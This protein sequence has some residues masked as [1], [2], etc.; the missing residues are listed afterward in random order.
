[1][2]RVLGIANEQSRA[3]RRHAL[4]ADIKEGR[5]RGTLWT[6]KTDLNRYPAPPGPALLRVHRTQIA[7]LAAVKTRLWPYP[8]STRLRLVNWGYALADAGLRVYAGATGP[9]PRLP[10]ADHP[11]D[12]AVG[13]SPDA[14][15]AD[16]LDAPPAQPVM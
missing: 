15:A 4:V 12:G 7:E 14:L 16:G 5:K 3:L 8:E 11:L 13:M 1:V 9:E 10:F 6:I 2:V